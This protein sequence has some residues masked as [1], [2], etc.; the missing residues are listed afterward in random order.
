[1]PVHFPEFSQR[2]AQVQ[3]CPGRQSS[4]LPS[5][6]QPEILQPDLC[7]KM[8]PP[9]EP[10]SPN[11]IAINSPSAAQKHHE[12]NKKWPWRWNFL[13]HFRR[14]SVTFAPGWWWIAP[15][16]A[17]HLDLLATLWWPEELGRKLS[18][19][20]HW[21]LVARVLQSDRDPNRRSP[22]RGRCRCTF[23][24][25]VGLGD[26]EPCCNS[27]RTSQRLWKL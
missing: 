3:L 11:K 17:N 20:R 19:N 1:M 6:E 2:S 10:W 4:C 23:S 21:D 15:G 24:L 26:L 12:L 22:P 13:L 14:K 9:R 8:W 25:Q 7:L 27:R 5:P 18:M 16:P